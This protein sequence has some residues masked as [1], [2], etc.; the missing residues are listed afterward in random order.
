MF[1]I[2]QQNLSTDENTKRVRCIINNAF[3]HTEDSGVALQCVEYVQYRVFKE[4]GIEINWSGRVGP[5]HGGT[6]TDH[7]TRLQRYTVIDEPI[8]YTA[9]SFANPI[10]NSPYGHVAFVEESYGD[11]SIKISEANYPEKGIYYERFLLKE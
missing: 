4:L 7:F 1:E 8:K 5:R 9:M 3:G 11:G 10:Y 6:W 2:G